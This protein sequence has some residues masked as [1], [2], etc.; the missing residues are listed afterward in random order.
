VLQ[1]ASFWYEFL[2][3]CFS[4][5][6]VALFEPL[7]TCFGLLEMCFWSGS[8]T[9]IDAIRFNVAKMAQTM[10]LGLLAMYIWMVMGMVSL[11]QWHAEGTCGNMFQCFCSYLFIA[12]RGDGVKDVLDGSLL[13][14]P[15]N[16]VDAFVGEQ[17]FAW[18]LAWDVSY[19]LLFVLILIAIIS[20]II[21]DAFSGMRDEV[22]AKDA[23]IRSVCFVCN[24]DRFKL[25]QHGIGFDRHIATEHNPRWYL[26]FLLYLKVNPTSTLTGQE[27]YVKN[28]VWPH[29]DFTW[30]PRENT[31]TLH[32]VEA[33]DE[34]AELN[35]KVER[36][37]QAF[38]AFDG[39]LA[40][41]EGQL[42]RVLMTVS[43]SVPGSHHFGSVPSVE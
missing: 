12:I 18:R 19:W 30:L 37:G 1:Q 22:D 20:G 21:I 26:F 32:V 2:F 17:V 27:A 41:I 34:L 33:D 31:L 4:V 28:A 40:A 9:A 24:L 29:K 11:R 39:R 36:Q 5:L 43:G 14:I 3:F 6:A 8:R 7:F 10:L 35:A 42:G 38:Q 25:D 23:D 13:V 16:I 15:G